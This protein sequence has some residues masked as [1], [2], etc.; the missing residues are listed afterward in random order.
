MTGTTTYAITLRPMESAPD[1]RAG[2]TV[3]ST[4]THRREMADWYVTTVWYNPETMDGRESTGERSLCLACTRRELDSL[5]HE[6]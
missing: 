2:R 1:P 4:K 3:C 6:Y 5:A